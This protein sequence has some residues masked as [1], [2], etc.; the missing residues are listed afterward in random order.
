MEIVVPVL[1]GT[2]AATSAAVACGGD[3]GSVRRAGSVRDAVQSLIEV[4]AD[5]M[6]AR[7]VEAVA[8]SGA[9]RAWAGMLPLGRLGLA[10]ETDAERAA[11]LALSSVLAALVLG[12]V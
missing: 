11:L 4:V 12:T 8:R 9:G 5:H 1:V 6:P 7:L 2:L 10:A 3:A